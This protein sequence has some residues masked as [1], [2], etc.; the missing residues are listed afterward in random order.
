MY[1][2]SMKEKWVKAQSIIEKLY[3]K[4]IEDD[5]CKE[6]D[7]KELE[8]SVGFLCHVSRTYPIIFPYLKGFYNTLNNWR[9]DQDGDGWKLSRTAWME[10]ISGDIAFE[11]DNDIQLPFDSRRRVMKNHERTAAPA[12]VPFVERLKKDLHAL[13][14]LFSPEEPTLRLVRGYSLGCALFAFGD[15]SGGGFGSS[16]QT[17]KGVSYR[18]STWDKS[19]D[20]QSSNLRELMNL[21]DT[22]EEMAKQNTLKGKELFP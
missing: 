12:F 11:E 21:V 14:V 7:Y 2:L 19:M 8:R 15:A 9:R 4:V 20:G 6:L 3:M 1:V 5:N 16:W 10:L 18:Y 17:T 22:I 13:R